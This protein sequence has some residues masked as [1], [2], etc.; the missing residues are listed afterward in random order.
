MTTAKV[1]DAVLPGAPPH[2]V[3]DG[4]P[5]HSLFSVHAV[6]AEAI[7][8][9]LM[10]DLAGPY[11]FA[12]SETGEPRGVEAHPHRGFETVTILYQGELQHRDSSGASGR[13]GPGDV[14][15]MTAAGGIVHEEKH[16]EAFTRAGGT[17]E[18]VQLWV[19]LPASKKNLPPSYQDIRANDIPSVELPG[20][21]GSLRVIAGEYREVT[22]PA[23]THT[24]MDVWD[25]QLNADASADFA[26]P[27][28]TNTILVVLRGSASIGSAELTAH[29]GVLLGREGESFTIEAGDSGA[30]L[31]LLS[32]EPINEPVAAR[33]PF[34]MN[35]AE[36]IVR[37]MQDYHGGKMGR[38]H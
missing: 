10:L 6:G 20:G 22:G 14:Q 32:G 13:L 11:D 12:P 30:A 36:E 1:V 34:V 18:M 29:Q 2:W 19:N 37:A 28:D 7:S 33:G 35:T 9:F 21:A 27:A 38:L 4:F 26:L 8:P 15:W 24:P 23:T 17:L 31:L 5:V 16:A 25:M 3:G